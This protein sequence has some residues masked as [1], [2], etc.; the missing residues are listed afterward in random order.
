MA[1]CWPTSGPEA[2]LSHRILQSAKAY[3]WH[4]SLIGLIVG[5]LWAGI[6]FSLWHD[7]QA[8]EQGAAKDSANLARSFDEDIT[9]TL[10]EVDQT[11]LF[12]RDAYRHD[13]TNG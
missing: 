3:A 2:G 11:L 8:A 13:R 9:R 10:E 1:I 12:L 4:L 5:L 6:G 7:Y